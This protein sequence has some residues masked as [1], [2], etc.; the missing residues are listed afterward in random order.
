MSSKKRRRPKKNNRIVA[1]ITRKNGK[2]Y[3]TNYQSLK[4]I[5]K[6]KKQH[7]KVSNTNKISIKT[8]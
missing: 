8:S 6:I 2:Y 7:K 4:N 3:Y 1:A 5:T